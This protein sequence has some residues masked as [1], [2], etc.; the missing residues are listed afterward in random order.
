MNDKFVLL[1]NGITIVAKNANKVV[2][3]FKISDFQIVNGCQT[4]HILFYGKD[5]ITDSLIYQI[6]LIITD[7]SEVINRVIKATNQQTEVKREAFETLTPF[8]KSL[9]EFYLSHE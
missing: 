4:S 5:K 3:A 8:H 7:D 9:E 6:K 2:T 1:N